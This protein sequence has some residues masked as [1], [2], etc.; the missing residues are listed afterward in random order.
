MCIVVTLK[1][2]VVKKWFLHNIWS[3]LWQNKSWSSHGPLT[4]GR[5]TERFLSDG[6]DTSDGLFFLAFPESNIFVNMAT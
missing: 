2:V 6:G 3:E 4:K 5:T 1:W